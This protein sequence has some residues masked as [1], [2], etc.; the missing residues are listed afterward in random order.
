[1]RS[2][3]VKRIAFVSFLLPLALMAA[4]GCRHKKQPNTPS[5][6]QTIAPAVAQPDPTGTDASTQTV[7]IDDSRSEDEGGILTDSSATTST[8][9]AKAAP[10]R[11]KHTKKK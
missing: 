5:A 8:G 4:S 11:T 1:M 3:P 9:G 7:D 10:K 6:T 2:E